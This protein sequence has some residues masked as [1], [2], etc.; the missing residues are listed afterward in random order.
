MMSASGEPGSKAPNRFMKEP[1]T[2]SR[3]FAPIGFSR[4]SPNAVLTEA[5][6][7]LG[8]SRRALYERLNRYGLRR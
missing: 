2:A 1:S 5:A 7:A 3:N 8:I 4:G 6:R